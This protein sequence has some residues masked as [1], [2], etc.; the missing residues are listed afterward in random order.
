MKCF[1][2][3]SLILLTL[4][5]ASLD[6]SAQAQGRRNKRID[7]EQHYRPPSSLAGKSV[8]IPIGT[9]FEGRIDS[10]IS[11]AKS[12]AGLRFAIIM[13]SPVLANG[14]EV[15][16][17]AG[18]QITG[19]VVEAIPA[20]SLPRKKGMP[21]PRGKLRVQ[22]NGLRTPD[23][24]TYPLVAS[25][26]GEITGRSGSQSTPLGT[27]VAYVG[28]STS[29]ESISPTTRNS[30]RQ[31][32]RSPVVSKQEMLKNEVYGLDRMNRQDQGAQ[33]R[34]L[35]VRKHDYYIDAGSPLTIRLSA[36]LKITISS[37]NTMPGSMETES[38]AEGSLPSASRQERPTPPQDISPRPSA[39]DF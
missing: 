12:H 35:Q 30:R 32:G 18:A 5:A 37:G 22:I 4:M 20:S 25:L 19:E 3:A 36:P 13:S 33:I 10:S 1:R 39:N 24:I 34:S 21:P 29:F 9:T 2:I 6:E 15:I 23:G 17:P 7:S 27:G 28:S 14:A 11:S 8:L 38:T 16:I 31:D 26:A